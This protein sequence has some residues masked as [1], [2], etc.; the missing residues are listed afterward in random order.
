M[1]VDAEKLGGPSTSDDDP[2]VTKV[3][4][5]LRR[6]K[7]DELLQLLNVVKG[8]MSLVGPRPEVPL[9]ADFYTPQERELLS[10][11]P[12]ITD[13]ASIRFR[14]EGEILK[15][16]SDPHQAYR[17]KIRPEKIRLG[18][19]YV[20]R[21]SLWVDLRIILATL[22]AIA[23][24][25]PQALAE[26]PGTPQQQFSEQMQRRSASAGRHRSET[27]ATN[28]APLALRMNWMSE[29][30][31]LTTISKLARE[32]RRHVVWMTHRARSS[33][34][35]T[36][37]SMADLLAVLYG[38]ILRVNPAEHDCPDRDRFILSKGHGAAGVYAVLAEKGFFPLEELETFYKDG[39]VLAGHITRSQ[40]PGVEA[41]T[42]SL[43]HGLGLACGMALAGVRDRRMYRVFTLLSD[44][45]CDEGSTWE[46]I[47]FASHHHLD[48]LVA[49]IDYNQIQSLATTEETLALEP[50][51]EKWR[52][53]GWSVREINGH[54]LREIKSALETVPSQAGR[55][56]CVIAHTVKGKG[57]S[58][59]ENSVLWHYRPPDK[60]ELR[61]ALAELGVAE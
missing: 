43:G 23:G 32:I 40:L 39:S 46:A 28:V 49:I 33:H 61:R 44:G 21:H 42:G 17:E 2:R 48:N 60:D 7:L 27:A 36:S 3:G 6:Y 53:F 41:S 18:L 8:E 55:P 24:G 29:K 9:E 50:F 31:D 13:W 26:M 37:L 15:G 5:P 12:G 34:V 56:S 25:K 47:L 14:N 22:W 38:A 57:V 10:V 1:V 52:A 51:A 59:M 58:F 20:K 4:K 54:D 30:A 19:E 11:R 35:G 45:D 16:S